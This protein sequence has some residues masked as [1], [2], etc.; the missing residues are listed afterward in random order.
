VL[1]LEERATWKEKLIALR[2]VILPAIIIVMV[3]GSMF[4]GICTPTEAA[5]AG[6]FGALISA[7]VYRRL[8]L[9][10]IKQ[11][12]LGTLKLTCMGLWIV[13]AA[14][15]FTSVYT[16][17]GAPQFMQDL[18]GNLHVAPIVIILLMQVAYF[19]LGCFMES[20]GIL[21]ITAPVFV[22]VVTFLG[23]DTVWFGV[24]FVVNMEMAFLTPPFGFNIFMLKG[25]VPEGITMQ[26]LY[27][28]V[29]PFVVLQGISLVLVILFPQIVLWLPRQLFS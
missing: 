17:L 2:A 24:L 29:W 12:C 8:N 14:A 4:A 19:V 13:T 5:G 16:G 7:A 22:P 15:T 9:S 11:A 23:F 10:V 25:V 1:P 27:K 20:M 26:D 3:L 6:A 18:L 28:S 21:M